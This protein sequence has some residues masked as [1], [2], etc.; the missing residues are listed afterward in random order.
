MAV[1]RKRV[2]IAFAVEDK[3]YRGFLR[4]QARL[5]SSPFDFIDMGVNNPWDS[6]WKTNCRSRV[7]SCDGLV[8][9]I[10][11]HTADAD[12]ELWEIHCAFEEGVPTMLM[13]I[14][15]ERPG[16]PALLKNRRINVWSWDN[17]DK[18]VRNL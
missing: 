7:K 6:Q 8:A 14:N 11:R 13:W 2:F 5:E 17:L 16:L 18:F 4:G 12:G 9:L 15:D 3:V 1:K 10:S